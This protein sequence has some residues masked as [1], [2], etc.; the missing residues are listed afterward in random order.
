MRVNATH[1]VKRAPWFD[2]DCR[3]AKSKAKHLLKAFRETNLEVKEKD[4]DTSNRNVK[5]QRYLG[6]W[7]GRSTSGKRQS[8]VS[9]KTSPEVAEQWSQNFQTIF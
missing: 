4:I 9:D 8:K 2:S 6:G 1:E 5:I 7:G 3:E